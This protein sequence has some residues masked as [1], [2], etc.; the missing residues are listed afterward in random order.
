MF[1]KCMILAA[2]DDDL[3][4]QTEYF[5]LSVST[6]ESLVD[7]QRPIV[8]IYITDN[9]KTISLYDVGL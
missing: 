1:Q 9:G 8:R 3:P 7:I 6:T 2:V 4:E 5:R